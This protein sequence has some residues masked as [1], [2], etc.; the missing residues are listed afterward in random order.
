MT[1]L[2]I[3]LEGCGAGARLRTVWG[4]GLD[5]L[6]DAPPTDLT[7]ELEAVKQRVWAAA[8]DPPRP[9]RRLAACAQSGMS[10]GPTIMERHAIQHAAQQRI[11]GAQAEWEAAASEDGWAAWCEAA[12]A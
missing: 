4:D 11:A 7:R 1:M 2:E 5:D 9:D 12:Q 8:G 10:G 6:L 3:M